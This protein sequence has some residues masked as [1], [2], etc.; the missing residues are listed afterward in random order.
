MRVAVIGSWR[1]ETKNFGWKLRNE[2][3]FKHLCKKVGSRL[4]ENNHQLIVART[5]RDET[6]NIADVFTA[7]GFKS[8]G[9]GQCKA[10]GNYEKSKVWAKAHISCVQEADAVIV[11][12]GSDGTYIAGQTAV[13]L[14]KRL[15]PIPFFG[16]AAE[17]LCSDYRNII[18]EG[19]L[20]IE[21]PPDKSDVSFSWIDA[22][23]EKIL[24]SLN[25]FPRILIIHGRSDDKNKL[26]KVLKAGRV[27]CFIGANGV[28]K[29]NILEALG[30]LGAA[31][32]HICCGRSGGKLSGFP[33]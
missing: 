9:K 26:K 13:M 29:S 25:L 1:K 11:I 8:I 14:G 16:G 27:N 31:Y 5:I 6:S 21:A 18:D 4:A 10:V 12:G 17:E 3:Y 23:I 7:D 32:F 22:L 28:G 33:A 20:S 2:A 19:V 30:V 15:I 24:G